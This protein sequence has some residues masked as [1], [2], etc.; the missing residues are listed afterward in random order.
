MASIVVAI[1]FYDDSFFDNEFYS[2]VAG[3]SCSEINTLE[4]LLLDML[5]YGLWV[6]AEEFKKYEAKVEQLYREILGDGR[7]NVSEQNEMIEE[8][9]IEEKQQQQKI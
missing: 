3:I 7:A 2:K 1:K 4:A 9:P 8:V 6:S 5:N